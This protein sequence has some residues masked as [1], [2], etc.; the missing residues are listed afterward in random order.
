LV[1]LLVRRASC[2]FRC[3]S[4]TLG[5]CQVLH[6]SSV[7][8]ST[9]LHSRCRLVSRR[10]Q[11]SP[12]E[13]GSRSLHLSGLSC[14]L[15]S[16]SRSVV[17]CH[18]PCHVL[19]SSLVHFITLQLTLCVLVCRRRQRPLVQHRRHL[20]RIFVF[21]L[22]SYSQAAAGNTCQ[23]ISRFQFIQQ[24]AQCSPACRRT[25]LR[26]RLCY[27]TGRRLLM[28]L[29]YIAARARRHLNQMT[30]PFCG[31]HLHLVRQILLS[32]DMTI[33][34]PTR[35][36]SCRYMP[37]SESAQAAELQ[38]HLRDHYERFNNF[39][40]HIPPTQIKPNGHPAQSSVLNDI[41]GAPHHYYLPTAGGGF[42]PHAV[43]QDYSTSS[44]LRGSGLERPM[45][46]G[47]PQGVCLW[48]PRRSGYRH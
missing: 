27:T 41:P 31:P 42:L 12:A 15:S 14:L 17:S 6:S 38:A 43:S 3:H 44:V 26:V 23:R 28:W 25:P 24:P 2:L 5:L 11:R 47:P 40:V 46:Q 35:A 34:G 45:L 9:S 1:L 36:L 18:M 33:S 4:K 19:Y 7:Q 10:R 37:P 48:I 39:G 20:L 13:H 32:Q 30:C 22:S 8:Q 21:L 16:H 29:I